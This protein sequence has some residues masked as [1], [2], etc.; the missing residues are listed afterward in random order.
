M[1]DQL[2]EPGLI[3]IAGHHQWPALGFGHD[4]A[5]DHFRLQIHE[6]L[7]WIVKQIG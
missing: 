3:G 6:Q 5:S 4:V 2:Y 7:R 1:G